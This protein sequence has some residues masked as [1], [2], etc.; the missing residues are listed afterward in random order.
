M[1][2][3]VE[4]PLLGEAF[5]IALD[6]AL[7]GPAT[8]VTVSLAV[9]DPLLLDGVVTDTLLVMELAA[10]GNTSAFKVMLG[11]DPPDAMTFDVVQVIV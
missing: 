10:L 4:S 9:G 2:S 7:L 1:P 5:S 8:T 3:P 6:M 11:A